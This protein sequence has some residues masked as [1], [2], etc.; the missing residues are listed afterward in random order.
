[1]TK[2]K[3]IL[4]SIKNRTYNVTRG[5]IWDIIDDSNYFLIWDLTWK[6][7]ENSVRNA[8]CT[9]SWNALKLELDKL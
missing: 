8:S 4:D 6:V 9:A 2:D 3:S 1:M 7:A 5:T